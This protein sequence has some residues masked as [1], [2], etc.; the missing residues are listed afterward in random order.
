MLTM[1]LFSFVLSYKII[2]F[3]YCCLKIKYNCCFFKANLLIC[4]LV[5]DCLME[6]TGQVFSVFLLLQCL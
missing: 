3:Y 1:G 4:L 6:L 2:V 5:Y